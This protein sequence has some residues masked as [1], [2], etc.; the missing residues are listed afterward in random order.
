MQ[1]IAA[2]ENTSGDMRMLSDLQLIYM[3]SRNST[4]LL[5]INTT[6]FQMERE[7]V[8]LETNHNPTIGTPK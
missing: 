6:K 2:L 8:C 4:Q 3:V 1:G 5:N 7:P